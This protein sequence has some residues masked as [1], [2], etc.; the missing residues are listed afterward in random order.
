[1]RIKVNGFSLKGGNFAF[2][3]G[4]SFSKSVTP[5]EKCLAVLSSDSFVY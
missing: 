1:M 2:F 4:P 5:K 3:F